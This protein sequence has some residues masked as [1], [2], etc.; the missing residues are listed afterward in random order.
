MALGGGEVRIRQS[1]RSAA[2]CSPSKGTDAGVALPLCLLLEK[3]G[4]L[5]QQVT[6]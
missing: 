3:F 6:L 1:L 4:W 2:A 5:V